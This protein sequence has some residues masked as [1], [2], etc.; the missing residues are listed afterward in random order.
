[1]S[2]IIGTA[3]SEIKEEDDDDDDN[4]EDSVVFDGWESDLD[5]ELE[6]TQLQIGQSL[7]YTTNFV[8]KLKFNV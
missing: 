4:K 1:M 2:A 8:S 6:W 5:F 3:V 7:S